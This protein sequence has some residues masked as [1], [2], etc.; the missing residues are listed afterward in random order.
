MNPND[1][2]MN[3]QLIQHT[4]DSLLLII[5]QNNGKT[6]LKRKGDRQ[7]ARKREKYREK[8]SDN[9]CKTKE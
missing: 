9:K 2:C 4:I 5:H 6:D 8:L 1:E 7:R 3:S